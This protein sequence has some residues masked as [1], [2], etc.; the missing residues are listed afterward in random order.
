MTIRRDLSGVSEL[1]REIELEMDDELERDEEGD[2]ELEAAGDDSELERA[3][4][5][6]DESGAE[7][8]SGGD[9]EADQ[10]LEWEAGDGD[11]DREYV[12]RFL[13]IAAREFE[14]EAEV[15]RAMNEA[16]NDVASEY[17]FGNVWKRARKFGTSLAKNKIVGSLV[18]KGLSVASG[19]LP[20]LKA[21]M[22]LAKGDLQGALLN[23][24]KQALG[25]AIPGGTA[26]LGA[27]QALGVNSTQ[28][29]QSNREAWENYVQISREAFEY[30]ADN[31]TETVDQPL[32]ASRLAAKSFQHAIGRAEQRAAPAGRPR[33][34][35]QVAIHRNGRVTRYRLRPG[36][37]LLITGARKLLVRG[38]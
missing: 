13:E 31:V 15:D 18:K 27:L 10:E 12:E 4:E 29:P 25:A 2:E 3:F 36:E 30:L 34:A 6:D 16:L 20:A 1:E 24:G 7:G 19:Q 11:R 14:S 8:E 37:K 5:A 26:A 35:G 28:D 22:Q 23:L 33:G 32:E 17:L 21:A 38:A 9:E